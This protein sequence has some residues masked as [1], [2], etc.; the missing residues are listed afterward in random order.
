MTR[1][2]RAGLSACLAALVLAAAGC[3][4]SRAT[5]SGKVTMQGKPVTAGTVLFVGT[6]NR[7]RSRGEG[8]KRIVPE[9]HGERHE[10]QHLRGG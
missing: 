5:V 7:N 10:G 3:G 8:D 1:Q 2:Y 9:T 4:P 6:D